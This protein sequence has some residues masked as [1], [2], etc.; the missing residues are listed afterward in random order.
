VRSLLASPRRRRRLLFVGVAL[1]FVAILGTVV[2]AF[3]NTS[4]GLKI[5]T[6]VPKGPLP[7]ESG[8]KLVRFTSSTERSVNAV[9]RRFVATAVTGRNVRASYELA[10][11]NMHEGMSRAQ[12]AKGSIPVQPY[13]AR[14]IEISRVVGSYKNDVQLEAT[15]LPRRNSNVGIA[16]VQVELK[17]VGS[18][19]DRRWLVDSFNTVAELPG[20]NPPPAATTA[21]PAPPPRA[22]AQSSKPYGQSHLSGRWLLLPAAIFGLILLIPLVLAA[23]GWYRRRQAYR[24]YASE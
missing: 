11:P 22:A 20:G 5:D 7:T 24:R 9:L 1:G 19:T 21:Q 2:A 4:A 10:T 17:A 13:P 23:K 8:P 3:W 6:S 15:L 14:S 18:G 16:V 12:W